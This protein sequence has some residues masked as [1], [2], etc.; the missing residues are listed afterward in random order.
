MKK[1]TEQ[2]IKGLRH[3]DYQR[4]VDLKH[5]YTQIVDGIGQGELVLSLRSRETTE[6]ME[7]RLNIT[8]NRTKAIYGK[9]EAFLKRVFR[10]DKI[11]FDVNT[12]KEADQDNLNKAISVFGKNGESL[13]KYAEDTALFLNGKDPNAVLWIMHERMDNLDTFDP[14][15]FASDEVL[16]IN[17]V[18]GSIKQLVALQYD[19]AS[20]YNGDSYKEKLIA[21]YWTFIEGEIVLTIQVDEELM[22][23]SDYYDQYFVE[24]EVNYYEIKDTVYGSRTWETE[25]DVLPVTNVGYKKDRQ[26]DG[27]TFVSFWDDSSELFTQLINVGS[28]YDISLTLHTF[29]QKVQYYTPCDYIDDHGHECRSGMLHPKN[30]ICPVC[31]G[32][33]KKIHTSGQDLI[34]IQYPDEDSIKIMPKDLVSYVDMPFQIVTHQANEVYSYPSKISEA[35]F[36]IDLTFTPNQQQTATANQNFYDT[37]YDVMYDF[38]SSPSHIFNFAVDQIASALGIKQ[39]DRRLVYSNNFN[40]ETEQDLFQMREQAVNSGAT[41]EALESIDRR[42]LNKQNKNNKEFMNVFLTMRKF[43]PFTNLDKEMKQEYVLGLNNKSLQKSLF[44]NFNQITHDIINNRKDFILL[45][46]DKQKEIVIEFTE[47]YINSLIE[48]ERVGTV[49]ENREDID[50]EE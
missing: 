20:Y 34:E 21:F 5:F 35:V 36:G 27:R 8:Q 38:T 28:Q 44:M 1:I 19:L 43:L 37:A 17:K 46:Y 14:F 32:S 3:Q 41:P 22:N 45:D 26:T 39:L 49:I 31:N 7:Q 11:A 9:L 40:L 4:T 13:L 47:P 6:Q 12:E 24:E 33:G 42:I 48:E 25:T 50:I 30:D 23:N 16:Y 29:L 2:V 15:I 18:K 10:T